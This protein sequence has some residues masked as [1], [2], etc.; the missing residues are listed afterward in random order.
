MEAHKGTSGNATHTQNG[1]GF[2]V[3]ATARQAH[4]QSF[5][6]QLR[7]KGVNVSTVPGALAN[8]DTATVQS[9][10]TSYFASHPDAYTNST[11][12]QGHLW[13]RTATQSS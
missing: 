5:I 6:T 12:S 10:L 2:T 13:N 11:R 3:N 9:W 8:N 7:N 4:L 1:H